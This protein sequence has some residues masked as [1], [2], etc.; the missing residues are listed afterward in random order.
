[1]VVPTSQK[2]DKR[3]KSALVVTIS[4]ITVGDGTPFFQ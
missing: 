4:S 2:A 3:S 1:M